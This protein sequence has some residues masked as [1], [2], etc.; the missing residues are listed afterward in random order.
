MSVDMIFSYIVKMINV[1]SWLLVSVWLKCVLQRE[2]GKFAVCSHC[3]AFSCD[4]DHCDQCNHTLPPNVKLYD[5]KRPK[6]E[7]PVH[8]PIAFPA[9]VKTYTRKQAKRIGNVVLGLKRP[10]AE[11][12]SKL[13]L[14]PQHAAMKVIPTLQKPSAKH[15]RKQEA[16]KVH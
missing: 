7:T 10:V 1:F 9:S 14:K 6:L 5:P 4:Y 3:G 12:V 11:D 15:F 8:S 2:E 16:G 13:S